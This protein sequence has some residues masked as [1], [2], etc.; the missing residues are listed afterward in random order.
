MRKAIYL[1]VLTLLLAG[2]SLEPEQEETTEPTQTTA[3]TQ[4][5]TEPATEAPTQA[6]QP[7]EAETVVDVDIKVPEGFTVASAT[8]DITVYEAPGTPRDASSIVV[9][10]GYQTDVLN[11]TEEEFLE[12]MAVAADEGSAQVETMTIVSVDRL[13]ALYVE[14]TMTVAEQP[15]RCYTYMIP[16]SD[17]YSFT[18]TDC[19]ENGAWAEDFA[20]SADSIKLLRPGES[21]LPDY[22]GLE[23]YDLGCGMGM[24]A[25]PGLKVQEVEGYDGVLIGGNVVTLVFSESKEQV[26]QGFTLEEYA[27][28]VTNS[29]GLEPCTPDKY[30]NLATVFTQEDEQ[31][32]TYFYYLTVTQTDDAY[33]ICQSACPVVDAVTYADAFSLWST[34]LEK[35]G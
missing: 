16:A 12:R 15:C 26:G 17:T 34:S 28:A 3:A 33:W 11:Y 31:G 30:G 32:D 9:R 2:C 21:A 20:K 14:Y 18:F 25:M 35:N 29:N 6:S 10:K 5:T 13:E 27:Q 24:Y 19:T 4:A 8:E 7:S 22:E 1:L 23:H